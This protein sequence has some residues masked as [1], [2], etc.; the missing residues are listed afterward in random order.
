MDNIDKEILSLLKTNGRLT[1]KEI[2]QLVHLTGQAV[3]NRISKLQENGT[4][5]HFTTAISYS[6]QQ[7]IMVYMDSNQFSRFE[8]FATAYEEIDE[9]YKVSGHAC[10][11]I[12]AH[13]NEADL[14][15]F[16]ERLT[17]WGRYNV[18]NILQQI[19]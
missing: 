1:N 18:E 15:A 13:F 3:G 10:Y 9:F 19:K 11:L 12:K 6:F 2:G 17:Y 5:I 7:Y 8:H 16:L 14:K 4:I